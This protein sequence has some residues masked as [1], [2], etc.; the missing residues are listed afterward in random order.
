MNATAVNEHQIFVAAEVTVGSPDFG[1]LEPMVDATQ[2]ELE[3]AGGGGVARGG[4]RSATVVERSRAT[5]RGAPF[6]IEAAG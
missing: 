6:P 2:R 1:H 4:M 3:R 5:D